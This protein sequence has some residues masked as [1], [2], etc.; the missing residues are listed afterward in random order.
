MPCSSHGRDEER[1]LHI[2][3]KSRSEDSLLVIAM[4]ENIIIKRYL[5]STLK[6]WP[7][8]NIFGKDNN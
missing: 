3:H 7:I 5:V 4:Q 1:I 2:C 8:P 6:V